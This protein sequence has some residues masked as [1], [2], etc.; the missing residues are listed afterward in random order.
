MIFSGPLRQTKGATVQIHQALQPQ[1]SGRGLT[2]LAEG[3]ADYLLFVR[4]LIAGDHWI[5]DDEMS[6]VC[7]CV[8]G[9]GLGGGVSVSGSVRVGGREV[10]PSLTMSVILMRRHQRLDDTS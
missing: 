3:A 8:L 5:E 6:C 4:R 10:F 1:R 2:P 7:V 9:K